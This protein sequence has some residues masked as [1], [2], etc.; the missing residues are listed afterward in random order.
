MVGGRWNSPGQQVIYGALSYACAMLEVLV[1]ANIGRVPATHVHVVAKVP[2]HLPM[3]RMD[4]LSLPAGW[5]SD[6]ITIARQVG[7]RWLKEA[8]TAVLI[9]PSVVAKLEWIA[10]VNP[11][12][13]DAHQ[14]SVSPTQPVVWDQRLFGMSNR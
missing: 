11:Q 4:A 14:L 5:D 9:L 8:R 13:P 3:E 12:H 6:G 10:V 2:D 7:D 1:H